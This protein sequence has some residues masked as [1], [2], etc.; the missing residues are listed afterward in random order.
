[1]KAGAKADEGKSKEGVDEVVSFS[2][3]ETLTLTF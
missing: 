2:D 3:T 1:V